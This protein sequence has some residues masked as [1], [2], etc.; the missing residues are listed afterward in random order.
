M[1]R[2]HCSAEAF[3]RQAGEAIPEGHAELSSAAD[4]YREM[5]RIR[6][7]MDDLISDNFSPEALAVIL[8]PSKRQ[9]FADAILQIRDKEQEALA[10]IERVIDRC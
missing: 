6:M 7:G 9:A 10:H 3:L 1:L 4:C 5:K 2:D 8:D